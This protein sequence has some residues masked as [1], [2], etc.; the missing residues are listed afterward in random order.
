ML[1]IGAGGICLDIFSS[2]LYFS[3]FLSPAQYNQP[4]IS[5]CLRVNRRVYGFVI[6]GIEMFTQ[7]D[8]TRTSKSIR[9]VDILLV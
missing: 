6:Y 1:A 3:S 9:P 8:N 5:P 7:K 2:V 4:F